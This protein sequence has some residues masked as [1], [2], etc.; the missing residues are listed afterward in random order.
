LELPPPSKGILDKSLLEALEEFRASLVS[1]GYS[2]K[3]VKAYATAIKKFAEHVGN[4]KVRE[5][6]QAD[7]QSWITKSLAAKKSGEDRKKAMNTMHYY[8]IFLRRFMRWAGRGDIF[9]PIIRKSGSS[10]PHVITEEELEA[11]NEAC[12][13]DL[14]RLIINLLFETGVRASELLE[15][16]AKDVDIES[17][18]ITLRSAKYGKA[19]TVFLGPKSMELV[20]RALKRLKPSDRLVGLTYWGLYKRLKRIAARA[21]VDVS[22]VRPHA[23]RHTFATVSLK[24]GINLSALQ[25]ILGHSDIKTTQIYL[26]LLKEDIKK[27]YQRA[28]F[29]SPQD[30]GAGRHAHNGAGLVR[31]CPNC[32]V[33]V[34]EGARYCFNCGFPVHELLV[35][36]QGGSAQAT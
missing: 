18:E 30:T 31:F 29:S 27:E 2:E 35:K 14:D 8:T 4:V 36:M 11:L 9:V 25:K 1:V 33:A 15:I 28:Y 17:G 20:S 3:T 34:I 13:D 24:R 12:R 5:V 22:S 26:H 16:R 21:S 6:T 19:R 32:G 7:V 23:F 10:E